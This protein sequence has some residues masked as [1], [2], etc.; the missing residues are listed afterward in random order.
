MTCKEFIVQY[1]LGCM[2][3]DELKDIVYR[4]KDERILD[5]LSKDKNLIIRCLVARKTTSKEILDRLSKD[6]DFKVR[7]YI[8]EN[9]NVPIK[10]LSYLSK[11][12]EF[13]VSANA[14][15]QARYVYNK[16]L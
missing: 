4:C 7:W 5:I 16:I 2:S 10:I 1:A 14:K 15:V 3:D 8:S 6:D 12:K 11:D 9:E 13:I